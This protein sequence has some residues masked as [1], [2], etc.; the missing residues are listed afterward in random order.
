MYRDVLLIKFH[1]RTNPPVHHLAP[2]GKCTSM[3]QVCTSILLFIQVVGIPDDWTIFWDGRPGRAW[4]R[5]GQSPTSSAVLAQDCNLC[6][7]SH[8]SLNESVPARAR[9]SVSPRTR[10]PC[11]RL[12]YSDSRGRAGPGPTAI[13]DQSYQYS[14]AS[15]H[16][17][18]LVNFISSSTKLKRQNAHFD[19]SCSRILPSFL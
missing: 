9:Q 18:R 10:C 6:K 1:T 15:A 19:V 8:A 2:S 13:K 12:R 4:R 17:P 14:N 3:K 5:S 16:P 11:D 7:A